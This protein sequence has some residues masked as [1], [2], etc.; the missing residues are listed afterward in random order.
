MDVVEQGHLSSAQ[1]ATQRVRRRHRHHDPGRV[2]GQSDGMKSSECNGI[3]QPAGYRTLDGRLWFPTLKGVAMID[4]ARLLRNLLPPPVVIEQVRVD[5]ATV[6]VTGPASVPPGRGELEFRFRRSALST[7]AG[8]ASSSGWRASTS[9]GGRRVGGACST[10]TFRRAATRSASSPATT[11]ASGTRPARRSPSGFSRTS[12]RRWWFYSALALG[13]GGSSSRGYRVRVGH[14][15]ARGR[16]LALRVEDRTK[17]LTI[18]VAQRRQAEAELLKAKEVAEAA[19]RAKS[20]FLANMSH[21]IRTPMNGVVG[22][23]SSGARLRAE[24]RAA[25]VSRDGQIVGGSSAHRHQRHS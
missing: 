12:I 20:E 25:R 6:P 4:P 1:A 24:A 8:T 13:F 3:G 2:Y 5:R 15:H 9:S 22:M 10:P 7:R 23:T 17:E 21:E 19:N 16:E 11:T 14:L 18:E